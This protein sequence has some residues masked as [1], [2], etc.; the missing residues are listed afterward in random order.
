MHE[1]GHS[2]PVHWENPQGW[3]GNGSRRGKKKF[4]FKGLER[5]GSM[6]VNFMKQLH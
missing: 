5:F 4:F 3:A 1:A 2:K 6:M